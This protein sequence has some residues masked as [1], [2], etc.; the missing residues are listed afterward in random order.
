MSQSTAYFAGRRDRRNQ[1]P[2][3][4]EQRRIS[5]FAE[6]EIARERGTEKV[7]RNRTDAPRNGD[8]VESD[9]LGRD[10][11]ELQ[12]ITERYGPLN[13]TQGGFRDL[14][15]RIAIVEASV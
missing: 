11:S 13:G 10:L 6:D 12:R 14:R 3:L 8:G 1:I 5:P 4:Q 15:V 2:R 7:E 9:A